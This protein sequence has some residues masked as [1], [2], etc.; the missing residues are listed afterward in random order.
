MIPFRGYQMAAGKKAYK[1]ARF[2]K[3]NQRRLH[4]FLCS[5]VI[6]DRDA[7]YK[8]AKLELSSLYGRMISNG[9]DLR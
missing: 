5:L 9:Q 6:L 8:K 1:K 2:R 7:Y 3:R 4:K